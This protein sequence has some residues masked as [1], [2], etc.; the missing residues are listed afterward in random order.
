MPN[1]PITYA[2]LLLHDQVT[3]SLRHFAENIC[4]MESHDFIPERLNLPEES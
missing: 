2:L 4:Q 1:S 3:E